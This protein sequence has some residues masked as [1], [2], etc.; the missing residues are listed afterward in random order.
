MA[1]PTDCRSHVPRA[2]GLMS[3]VIVAT[4][5]LNVGA[6]QAANVFVDCT[7]APP[8]GAF[9]S[10]S[11]ALATLDPAGPNTIYVTGDCHNEFL[12]I[13]H[14]RFLTIAAATPGS[15]VISH[16]Q[17]ACGGGA[18][19]PFANRSVVHILNSSNI[20]LVDLI[21]RGGGSAGVDL[22]DAYGVALRSVTIEGNRGQGLAAGEGSS[23]DL[24]GQF[25]GVPTANVIQ[26]NCGA[27]IQVNSNSVVNVS[28]PATIQGNGL[29]VHVF[30]GHA[31]LGGGT[32]TGSIL[33]QNNLGFG[34][35]VFGGA[36][37]STGRQTTIQ[38]NNNAGI[39]AAANAVVDAGGGIQVLNNNGPGIWAQLNSTVIFGPIVN[40]SATVNVTIAGNIAEG[41]RLEHMSLAESFAGVS[42]SGNGG[43]DATCDGTST[44]VG[45]TPDIG[46]NLCKKP[47]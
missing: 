45:A 5:T 3:A 29:G 19:D 11:A 8:P 43:A 42:M 7:G 44:L 17:G 31:N 4:L 6:A 14:F 18:A 21:I 2:L 10:I 12:Q 37:L 32:G 34:V 16:T 30:G 1:F 9:T 36:N 24:Q 39:W 23:A 15:A 26:N 25:S 38:N 40:P 20:S 28:S 22:T 35:R 46:V 41:L 47:K 33:I 13:V 27:G